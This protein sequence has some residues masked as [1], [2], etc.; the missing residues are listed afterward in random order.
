MIDVPSIT[1]ATVPAMLRVCS[2]LALSFCFL[3]SDSSAQHS[4]GPISNKNEEMLLIQR[5][6]T[7]DLRAQSQVVRN[8]ER[9]DAQAQ[10]AMGDNYE[11][12]I[13]VPKDH[14]EALRWYRKAAVQGDVVRARSSA[15]CITTETGLK[16]TSWKRPAGSVVRSP[17]RQLLRVARRRDML[18]SLSKHSICCGK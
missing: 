15:G 10:E 13:W 16:K 18:S 2:L 9:G 5:A 7:G 11:R 12:G 17:L 4:K 1:C 8:A 3:K 14:A 6:E